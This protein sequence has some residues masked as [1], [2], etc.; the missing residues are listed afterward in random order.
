MEKNKNK[1]LLILMSN[2][3]LKI[4]VFFKQKWNF[5]EFLC[6][7]KFDRCGKPP[8]EG[9]ELDQG[10]ILSST[11]DQESSFLFFIFFGLGYP[12]S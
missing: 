12:T 9:V 11:S 3:T 1:K 5:N 8:A 2:L 4:N 7:M 10:L 6:F